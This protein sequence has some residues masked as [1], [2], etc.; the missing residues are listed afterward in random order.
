MNGE[1]QVIKLTHA[2]IRVENILA[3]CLVEC[4]S[5]ITSQAGDTVAW[6][7]QGMCRWIL[8]IG[9]QVKWES[10]TRSNADPDKLRKPCMTTCSQRQL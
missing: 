2:P 9:L 3:Q 5:D 1:K 6:M 8:F 7:K 4:T 10:E